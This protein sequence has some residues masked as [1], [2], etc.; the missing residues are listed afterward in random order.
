MV[1]KKA[2]GLIN[3][4]TRATL[5]LYTQVEKISITYRVKKE[6]YEYIS[7]EDTSV[8]YGDRQI[9]L[10]T[11]LIIL[12]V[13]EIKSIR[14]IDITD[15]GLDDI[16]IRDDQ[17]KEINPDIDQSTR[18]VRRREQPLE[19]SRPLVRF[20]PCPRLQSGGFQYELVLNCIRFQVP[21]YLTIIISSTIIVFISLTYQL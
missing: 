18:V 19:D 12:E 2:K 20:Y 1:G 17:L 15:T 4:R 10:E 7:L 9:R 8:A 11:I 3:S 13:Q 5:I 21:L 14:V 6:L 16:L